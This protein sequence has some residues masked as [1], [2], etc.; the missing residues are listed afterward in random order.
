MA[1]DYFAWNICIH[2]LN[3]K[4]MIP[5]W[6]STRDG[7]DLFLL[8]SD[9]LFRLTTEQQKDEPVV[10]CASYTMSYVL[11]GLVV[12]FRKLVAICNAGT[13]PIGDGDDI[14]VYIYSRIL[15]RFQYTFLC[16]QV[17]VRPREHTQYERFILSAYP[18]YASAFSMMIGLFIFSLVFLHHK[19]EGK[20]KAE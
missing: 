10:F 3:E 20:S 4:N 7:R 16:F 13:E 12:K 15:G 11:L 5:W 19:D 9:A 17:S 2:F 1:E 8:L 14:V 18:Y 6:G